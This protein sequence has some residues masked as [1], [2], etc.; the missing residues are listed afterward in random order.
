M[1]CFEYVIKFDNFPSVLNGMYTKNSGAGITQSLPGQENGKAIIYSAHRD[2]IPISGLPDVYREYEKHWL[3]VPQTSVAV[4]SFHFFSSFLRVRLCLM[5]R[6]ARI[7]LIIFRYKGNDCP[8]QYRTICGPKFVT[9]WK[10]QEHAQQGWP[11]L[12]VKI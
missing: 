7:T 5:S 8:R 6:A 12:K 4:L 9:G 11:N 10:S 2:L 1:K 3:C